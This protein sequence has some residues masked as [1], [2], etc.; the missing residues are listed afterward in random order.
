MFLYPVKCPMMAIW[1]GR[2]NSRRQPSI[3]IVWQIP[4]KSHDK[5]KALASW[6]VETGKDQVGTARE[7]SLQGGSGCSKSLF[8]LLVQEENMA[9]PSDNNQIGEQPAEGRQ[10]KSS[11]QQKKPNRPVDWYSAEHGTYH[12]LVRD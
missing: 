10:Q 6:A 5:D 2:E 9:V 7:T 4:L 1:T 8:W 3:L 11:K 12:I